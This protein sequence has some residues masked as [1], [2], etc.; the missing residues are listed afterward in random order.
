MPT[1]SYTVYGMTCDHCVRAVTEELTALPGVEQVT[2]DLD[3]GRV[4]VAS[5]GPLVLAEVRTA[6]EEA[7]YTLE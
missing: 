2:V 3:R 1:S 7:G 6:I 4:E 5:A